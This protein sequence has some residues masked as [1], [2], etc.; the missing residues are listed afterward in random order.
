V[1]QV[2]SGGV[3]TPKHTETVDLKAGEVVFTIPGIKDI[4]GSPVGDTRTRNNTPD[5][6]GL[7]GVKRVKPQVY[8]GLFP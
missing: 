6:E 2:D 3:F 5:V 7:P 1:H 4:H 8:S